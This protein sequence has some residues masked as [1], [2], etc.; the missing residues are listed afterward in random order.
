MALFGGST[1]PDCGFEGVFDGADTFVV[2]PC[3]LVLVLRL[4]ALGQLELPMKAFRERDASESLAVDGRDLQLVDDALGQ[5]E[6]FATIGFGGV[7]EHLGDVLLDLVG[8]IDLRHHQPGEGDDAVL[9][10]AM[11][12]Q[13]EQ[14]EVEHRLVVALPRGLAEPGGG[15]FPS[16]CHFGVIDVHRILTLGDWM[17]LVGRTL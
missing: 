6:R 11:S 10:D 3:E 4:T 5:L 2:Y 12:A 16:I 9:R 8:G 15:F 14:T 7:R 1:A 17:T 13:M